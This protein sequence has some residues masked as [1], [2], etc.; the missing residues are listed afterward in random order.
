MR[1]QPN[2]IVIILCANNDKVLYGIE[3]TNPYVQFFMCRESVVVAGKA[4]KNNNKDKTQL[5]SPSRKL[6]HQKKKYR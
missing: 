3:K 4:D 5:Q 1:I 2:A 6:S